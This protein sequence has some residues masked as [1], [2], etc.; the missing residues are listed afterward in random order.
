[1][2]YSE[3]EYNSNIFYFILIKNF[4]SGSMTNT[5]AAYLVGLPALPNNL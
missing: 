5:S 1:M 2:A 3:I 4:Y